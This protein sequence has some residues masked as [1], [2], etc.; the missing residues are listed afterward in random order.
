MT[1]TYDI[2]H[3][4]DFMYMVDKDVCPLIGDISIH[5]NITRHNHVIMKVEHEMESLRE[6]MIKAEERLPKIKGV[7]IPPTKIIASNDPSLS[8]PLIPEMAAIKV[9][10]EMEE[11]NA[12]PDLG[13]FLAQEGGGCGPLI[14]QRLKVVNNFIQPVK[15]TYGEQDKSI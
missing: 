13:D 9:E 2:I 11:Y 7:V 15:W 10:V 12:R 5:G 14:M 3:L 1:K 4:N 6:V 8:L